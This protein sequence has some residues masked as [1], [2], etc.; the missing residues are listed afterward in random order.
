V[1]QVRFTAI[2]VRLLFRSDTSGGEPEYE[3]HIEQPFSFGEPNHEQLVDPRCGPSDSYLALVQKK[4]Q[5]AT[6]HQ[7][8]SL[9]VMFVAGQRLLIPA[10]PY[11]AWNF[12]GDDGTLVVSS[13]GGGLA[14]WDENGVLEPLI[15]LN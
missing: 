2:D 10:N 3:L 14:I 9:D 15:R 5:S 6:A 1:S 13:A 12:S 11:E 8:G 7:D 4:V